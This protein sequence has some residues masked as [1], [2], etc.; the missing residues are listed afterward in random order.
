MKVIPR[1]QAMISVSTT[2]TAPIGGLNALNPISNMPET[3]A[4]VMRNFFPEPFGC[5]VRKGYKEHA[6]GLDGAVCSLLTFASSDGTTKLFAVDQSNV[7]D[8]TAPGDY[9]AATPL[10]ASANP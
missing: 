5:R 4:I 7:F 6:T 8:V 1:A 10:C 3:D 9:S 2:V